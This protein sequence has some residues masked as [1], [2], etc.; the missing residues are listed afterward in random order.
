MLTSLVVVKISRRPLIINSFGK[1]ICAV[2]E[3]V[4]STSK[5]LLVD[6]VVAYLINFVLVYIYRSIIIIIIIAVAR[7]S[8]L[9]A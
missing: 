7:R 6:T 9:S 4:H 1:H 2:S 5:I 8:R 3:I